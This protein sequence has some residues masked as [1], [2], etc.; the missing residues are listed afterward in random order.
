MG[1]VLR[2][3]VLRAHGAS[4]DTVTTASLGHGVIAGVEVLAVLEVLGEVIGAGW[5][6]AVEAE[7]ALLLGG[8]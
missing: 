1:D 3:R 4:I 6:F 2:D 7:Q 8:E 5:E